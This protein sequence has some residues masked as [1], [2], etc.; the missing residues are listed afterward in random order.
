MIKIFRKTRQEN[1]KE[2]RFS[3]YLVYAL[4]EI[5][6]VV[7]GILIALWINNWN[8]EKRERQ[9]E[10]ALLKKLKEENL[11]NLQELSLDVEYRREI[12]KVI[13]KFENFLATKD[14][15]KET[16]SLKLYLEQILR[17]TAYSF[18]GTNLV[19]YM[20]SQKGNFSNLNRELSALQNIQQDLQIIS[21]KGIEIKL[22]NLYDILK[23]DVNF[24]TLK[25]ISFQNLSSLGFRNDMF[26]IRGV[27]E[28]ISFKFR[29]ALIQLKKVDSLISERIRE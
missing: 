3:N 2:K 4:G 25:I 1:I 22:K 27:E 14:I 21:D 19:N 8:E 13:L 29:K 26:L 16:D 18:T 23:N 12:P 15:Q 7:V 6:L 11:L 24:S 17:S 10:K 5:I 28:E 20:N 9:Q